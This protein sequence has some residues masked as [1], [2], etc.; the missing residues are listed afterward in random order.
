MIQKAPSV[1]LLLLFASTA[2]S[3]EHPTSKQPSLSETEQWMENATGSYSIWKYE[4]ETLNAKWSFDGC[5]VVIKHFSN[6]GIQ[7]DTVVAFSLSDLDPQAVKV[8]SDGVLFE[9]TNNA[10]KVVLNPQYSGG[11]TK[12]DGWIANLNSKEHAQRF[13]KALRHAIELCGGQKSTF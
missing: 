10:D 11:G 4:G 7:P 12:L 5:K 6:S 8:L 3:Q 2:F 13:G 1:A 9:T